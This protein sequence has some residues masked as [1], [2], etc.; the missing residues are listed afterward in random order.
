M[1]TVTWTSGIKV[2][3]KNNYATT[4]TPDNSTDLA[5]K[6]KEHGDTTDGSSFASS[7]TNIVLLT[8]C[9]AGSLL[10]AQEFEENLR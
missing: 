7:D 4:V 2:E 10:L 8:L 6:R 5:E 1:N 3:R 9:V